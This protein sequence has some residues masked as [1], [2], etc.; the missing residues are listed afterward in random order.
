MS[1]PVKLEEREGAAVIRLS[2]IHGNAINDDLLDGIESALS[3]SLE[4]GSARGLLLASSGKLFCPGL[5]LQILSGYDRTA[6]EAFLRK[7]SRCM[8]SLYTYPG[9]VV[10]AINGP[11][12]A[13]GCVLAMTADWRVLRRGARIG[14]NEIKVGVPLPWGVA[15][16]M[17]EGLVASRIEEVCLLGLNYSDEEALATGLAHEVAG[18]E[19]FEASAMRRLAEFASK[20]AKAFHRTKEYLRASVA[21]RIRSG[22]D[23]RRGEFLDC[24]FSDPTRK[25]IEEIVAGLRSRSS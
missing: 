4:G 25:R 5:D 19:G 16:I 3:R 20:D 13:G 15:Q 24:W 17:R 11:A 2:G 12:V 7:F 22:E 9:P 23:E 1:L 21:E 14:L 10:A 18:E 6:M 8:L